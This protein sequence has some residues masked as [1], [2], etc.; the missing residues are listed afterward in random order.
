MFQPKGK[1]LKKV[2]NDGG[3]GT[4][5]AFESGRVGR[6]YTGGRYESMDT[7]GYS[8]GKENFTVK[9]SLPGYKPTTEEIKRKD[10]TSKIKEFK[11]GATRFD[12]YKIKRKD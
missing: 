5:V 3:G 12:N 7:T 11:K 10:V 6:T 8:K 9:T 2:L 4:Y 1:K